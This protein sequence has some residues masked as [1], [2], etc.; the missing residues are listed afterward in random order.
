MRTVKTKD[1]ISEVSRLCIEAAYYLGEDVKEALRKALEKEKAPLGKDVLTEIIKNF[2][3]AER[4]HVPMCQD[5]GTTIVFVDVGRDAYIDGPLEDAINEGVRAGYEEGYLRKSICDPMTRVNTNDNTPAVIHTSIVEGDKVTIGVVT[6]GSGSENMSRMKMLKPSDGVEGIR[7][8]I[9]EAVTKG[10]GM[11]CPPIVIGVGIGGDFEMA[12]ILAKRSLF[13]KVGSPNP[14][15]ALDKLEHELLEKINELG[16]GPMGF[17]G[18]ITAL[19]INISTQ[20]CHIASLPV[21][22][23]IQCHADRHKVAVL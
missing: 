9:I 14:D 15:K 23:N 16:V 12:P 4:E 7:D 20:P 1:I 18:L 5:T 17:G 13:R 6:K 19:A 10:G 8:F 2:E 3:I 22:I 21:A 11:P